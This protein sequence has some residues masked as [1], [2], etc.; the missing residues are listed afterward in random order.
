MHR[1]APGCTR[2]VEEY[3]E[4]AAV[5]CWGAK[6]EVEC[7]GGRPRAMSL[8]NLKISDAECTKD[9]SLMASEGE[10]RD[11]MSWSKVCTLD[12]WRVTAEEPSNTS[13]SAWKQPRRW[14]GA[15]KLSNLI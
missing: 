1:S 13:T 14:R 15:V 11:W 9:L 2:W 5:L 3:L 7:V 4:A 12:R 8:R 6:R 10:E